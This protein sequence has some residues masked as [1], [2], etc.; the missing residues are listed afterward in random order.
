MTGT[1]IAANRILPPAFPTLRDTNFT[2]AGKINSCQSEKSLILMR[3]FDRFLK[4]KNR[5]PDGLCPGPSRCVGM[6]GTRIAA[7][8]IL[9][10]AF[11]TLR[12][13]NFTN[14]GKIILAKVKKA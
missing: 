9:S 10:P 7:N 14:A 13:T 5:P 2:N 1:R 4:R 11:P 8:R 3:V 12:D 6:T